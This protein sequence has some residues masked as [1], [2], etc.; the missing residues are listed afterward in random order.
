MV[1][2]SIERVDVCVRQGCQMVYFQTKDHNLGKFGRAL[3][4]KRLV[5]RYILWPIGILMAISHF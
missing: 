4:L 3:E 1:V 5:C 2:Q